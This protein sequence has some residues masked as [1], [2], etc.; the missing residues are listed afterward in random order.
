MTFRE[1]F[2]RLFGPHWRKSNQLP[3]AERE[4]RRVNETERQ[5]LDRISK[6]PR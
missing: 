3:D 6:L 4:G 5:R 2:T 1:A